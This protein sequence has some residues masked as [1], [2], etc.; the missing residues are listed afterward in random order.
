VGYFYFYNYGLS[1]IFNFYNEKKLAFEI[2]DLMDEGGAPAGTK[3]TLY[4][5]LELKTRS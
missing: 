1:D 5:P 3:V 4:V 2:E